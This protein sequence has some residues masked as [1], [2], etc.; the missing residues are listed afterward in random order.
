[1]RG[2]SQPTRR[3]HRARVGSL[4]ERNRVIEPLD[5]YGRRV[6]ALQPAHY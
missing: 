5:P 2:S 1:M 6:A 4:K 3:H